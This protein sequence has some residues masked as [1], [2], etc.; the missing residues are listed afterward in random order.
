MQARFFTLLAPCLL[1]LL[2]ACDH[3][4]G[5]TTAPEWKAETIAEWND[6]RPDMLVLSGDK[7]FLFVSFETRQN[8]LAPSLGRIN[9][10]AGEQEILLYG[11]A[12]ADGLKMDQSGKL[13]IGEEVADGEIWT[14]HEPEMLP[15]GQRVDRNRHVASH[16]DIVAVPSAGRFSHEGLAFSNDG[17]YLYLADEWIEGCL[18]RFILKEQKLQVL[19][20]SRGWLDIERAGEAR[21]YAEK[22]H[23]RIFRR[24]EDM[25][26]LPDGRIL[27]AETG[28]DGEHGRILA[29]DNRGD[30]PVVSLFLA[31][32]RLHHPDNLEWDEKRGW[33]WI[34]DDDEPSVLWAWDGKELQR[35]AWHD[36]AEIT[37]VESAADG[38]IYVNLQGRSFDPDLTVRLTH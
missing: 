23:G 10:H 32:T 8:Q 1:M 5:L 28:R 20:K 9:L 31:D 25:E 15:A 35:I 22:S 29:L 18:Y 19:H 4:H 13:W 33:L 14:I 7:R 16:Q 3:G 6:A 26:P 34:T 24:L 11:L 12:R 21:L 30:A 2:G 36:H 38:A 27:M 37:G 17:R